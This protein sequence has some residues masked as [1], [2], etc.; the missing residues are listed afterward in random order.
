MFKCANCRKPTSNRNFTCDE[1]SGASDQ[2]IDHPEALQVALD[3]LR[4][5]HAGGHIIEQAK[6]WNITAAIEV[7]LEQL[8]SVDEEV[9]LAEQDAEE[10]DN[11]SHE[12]MPWD[13]H[14]CR[15]CGTDLT[16][17]PHVP[18]CEN[19]DPAFEYSWEQED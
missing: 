12:R 15:G 4:E 19:E 10:P 1:C 14:W 13:D 7:R 16:R 6:L 5:L 9:R 3:V 2:Q 18:G 17:Y 8:T 11:E